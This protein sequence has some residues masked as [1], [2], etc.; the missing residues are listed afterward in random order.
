VK[1]KDDR[2]SNQRGGR[3]WARKC[4]VIVKSATGLAGL[5]RLAAIQLFRQAASCLG[6]KLLLASH[7]K[8]GTLKY[9]SA[10]GGGNKVKI[11]LGKQPTPLVFTWPKL[12]TN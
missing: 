8:A 11:S 7:F 5:T 3:S 1:S 12:T 10:G 2:R 6:Q 9:M 4:F